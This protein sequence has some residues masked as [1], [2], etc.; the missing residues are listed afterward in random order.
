MRRLASMLVTLAFLTA[1]DDPNG[2][3]DDM[4]AYGG[5]D[6]GSWWDPPSLPGRSSLG[7][8]DEV[9]SLVRRGS[10]RRWRGTCSARDTSCAR[11]ARGGRPWRWPARTRW[12][13]TGGGRTSASRRTG[14]FRLCT[15]NMST[16]QGVFKNR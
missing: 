16:W 10:P 11:P 5:P 1:H 8:I 2:T 6:G 4:G 9:E 13:R 14:A 12:R 7:A 3:R 15:C